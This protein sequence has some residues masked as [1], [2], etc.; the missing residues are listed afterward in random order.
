MTDTMEFYDDL[1]LKLYDGEEQ[2]LITFETWFNTPFVSNSD[3]ENFRLPS[4]FLRIYQKSNGIRI[5]WKATSIDQAYGRMEFLEMDAVLSN[6]ENSIYES[7]DLEINEMLEFFKPFDQVSPEILCGFM[8]SPNETAKSIYLNIAGETDTSSLGLDFDGYIT[9]LY[10]SRAY[11]NWPII[12]L[13]IKD[14]NLASPLIR[15]FRSD[16]PILFPDFDWDRYF[17]RYQSL[18][19]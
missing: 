10:E 12:L 19:L 14:N 9:M 17:A 13:N 2:S 1:Q 11:K 15:D 8:I 5:A 4:S 3:I 18:R 7:K 6:W 16:M